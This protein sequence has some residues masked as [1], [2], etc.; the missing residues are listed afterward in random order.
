MHMLDIVIERW[1]ENLVT[2][3]MEKLGQKLDSNGLESDSN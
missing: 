1:L 3:V 2:P